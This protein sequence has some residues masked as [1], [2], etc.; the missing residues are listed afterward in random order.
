[1]RLKSMLLYAVSAAFVLCLAGCGAEAPLVIDK[2]GQPTDPPSIA[3]A[4][5]T[6]RALRARDATLRVGSI[7]K[8]PSMLGDRSGDQ[9]GS[10]LILVQDFLLS[11]LGSMGA[12]CV[13]VDRDGQ[14]VIEGLFIMCELFSEGRAAATPETLPDGTPNTRFLTGYIDV[15]GEFV[16]PPRFR[17]AADFREGLALVMENST[18][19][20]ID[21]AGDLVIP[22]QYAQA[23]DFGEGLAAVAEDADDGR[24]WRYIDP[25]G[26]TALE[27]PETVVHADV[28]SD[29]LAAVTVTDPAR[30]ERAAKT[31]YIGKSG[32]FVIEPQ[33]ESAG[34]FVDG[35]AP[36]KRKGRWGYI[37][38]QGE[39]A[40]EPQY[41]DAVPFEGDVAFVHV[42][43]RVWPWQSDSWRE[44][45]YW[46]DWMHTDRI[47][48][49]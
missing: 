33:F 26:A 3:L 28:F 19:G 21:L 12:R 23:S 43:K 24:R 2:Q 22:C 30:P 7:I 17:F 38:K 47:D 34:A 10:D 14:P 6:V 20:F 42:R 11:T 27:L 31:G 9:P 41:L 39:F 29:G 25:T 40:I 15:A 13:F 1:M 45:M 37:D 5:E 16:I 35:L 18:F 46:L 8:V 32:A 36:A 4:E 48:I 44:C 49:L